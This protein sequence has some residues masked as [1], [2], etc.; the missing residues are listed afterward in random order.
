VQQNRETLDSADLGPDS[1][2]SIQRLRPMEPPRGSIDLAPPWHQLV[3]AELHVNRVGSVNVLA[4]RRSVRRPAALLL[5][6]LHAGA[7][8]LA[9]ADAILDVESTATPLHMESQQAS[10]SDAHH[11]HLFCQVIRSL[12]SVSGAQLRPTMALPGLTSSIGI[13]FIGGETP[14]SALRADGLGPRGPPLA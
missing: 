7:T 2:G 10:H 13:E 6:F 12:S 14:R 8:S 5:A 9:A 11:D 4:S 1:S 3:S